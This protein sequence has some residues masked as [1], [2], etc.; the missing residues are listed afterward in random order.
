MFVIALTAK[1]HCEASQSLK[2][3]RQAVR[4]IIEGARQRFSVS[5]AEVGGQDTWQR[6]DIGIALVSGSVS[7]AEQLA[8]DV[9]RFIWSFPDVT[10]LT[11]ERQWMELDG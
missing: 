10:V 1:L 9:E 5:V 2:Q 4:P 8:D 11:I 6:C 7:V 3:R